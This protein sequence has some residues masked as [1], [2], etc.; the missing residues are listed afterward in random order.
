MIPRYE[1]FILCP[2]G[3]SDVLVRAK[4]MSRTKPN[5]R[6]IQ[7]F[8][9]AFEGVEARCCH[10]ASEVGPGSIKIQSIL[11]S[12]DRTRTP[13]KLFQHLPKEGWHLPISSNISQRKAG[14]SQSQ[15]ENS[16]SSYGLPKLVRNIPK[17]CRRTPKVSWRTPR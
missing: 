8:T 1:N 14:N 17:V 5:N 3:L 11:K 6:R 4:A 7:I 2:N 16:Q 13:P 12:P 10:P 15:L 9:A